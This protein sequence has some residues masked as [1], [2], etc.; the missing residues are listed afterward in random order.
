MPPPGSPWYDNMFVGK[1]KLRTYLES[2]CKEA[3]ITE[4]KMNHS[5]R[6]TG[7][8]TLFNVGVPEKLNRDVTGHQSSTLQLHK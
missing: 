1:E 8:L 5:L 3:G 2:M 7:A 6:G 4:K